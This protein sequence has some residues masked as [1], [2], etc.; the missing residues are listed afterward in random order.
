M[1]NDITFGACKIFLQDKLP[2]SIKLIKTFYVTGHYA[3]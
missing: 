1:F 2:H 3:G